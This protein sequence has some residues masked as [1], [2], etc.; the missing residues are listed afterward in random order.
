MESTAFLRL[1]EAQNP[2]IELCGAGPVHIHSKNV[3]KPVFYTD[4]VINSRNK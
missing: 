1:T 3:G 2:H 4:L